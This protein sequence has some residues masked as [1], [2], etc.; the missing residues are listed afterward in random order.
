MRSAGLYL[1]DAPP[2]SLASYISDKTSASQSPD[3]NL[4][5]LAVA[6]GVFVLMSRSYAPAL[7]ELA[8]IFQVFLKEAAV[9]LF[10]V[11]SVMAAVAGGER[12]GDESAACSGAVQACCFQRRC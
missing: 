4:Q 9:L 10:G 8:K 11:L 1:S 7:T 12:N 6:P 5:P 3:A 2:P